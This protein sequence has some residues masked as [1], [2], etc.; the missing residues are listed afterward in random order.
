MLLTKS[1]LPSS[2][3]YLSSFAIPKLSKHF[4]KALFFVNSAARFP[5]LGIYLKE[6][7]ENPDKFMHRDLSV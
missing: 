5:L 1:S 3:S 2:S 7:I 6:I 4:S